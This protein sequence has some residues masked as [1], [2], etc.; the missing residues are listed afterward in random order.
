MYRGFN[1]KLDKNIF[2]SVTEQKYYY[3]KERDRLDDFGREFSKEIIK[4]LDNLNGN[5]IMEEWFPIKEGLYD[6]FLSHSHKDLEFAIAIAGKLREQHQLNVFIDSLI[7]GNCND[8]LKEIDKKYCRH[9]DG[10]SYD[11]D[12]RNYSTSHIHMM[13]M[14]SLNLMIDKCEAL[15]FLNTPNSISVMNTI[16]SSTNSPWIFSEIQTSRVIR[17]RTPDRLLPKTR[18]FSNELENKVQSLN[19][20]M[21]PQLQIDY[22]MELSHL[23][24]L[25]NMEFENWMN[26]NSN[27]ENALDNLYRKHPL[28]KVKLTEDGNDDILIR[29]L[30]NN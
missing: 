5:E 25:R 18:F 14:N 2:S 6:I 24:E 29:L 23:V 17:K 3:S 12:K 7:W 19:E 30:M 16:E 15:F 26:T 27:N 11:Y 8:L 20:S 22:Q 9:S 10:S 21:S 4:N 1:L 13:L 28:D